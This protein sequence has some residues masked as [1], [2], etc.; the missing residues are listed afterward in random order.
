MIKIINDKQKKQSTAFTITKKLF[1][2][3]QIKLLTIV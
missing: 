2:A 3:L 1:V